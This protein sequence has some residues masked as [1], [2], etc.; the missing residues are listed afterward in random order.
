MNM[1]AL[2]QLKPQDEKTRIQ[3][4]RLEKLVKVP[5]IN[6]I[7][8]VVA[9]GPSEHTAPSVFQAHEQKLHKCTGNI[10]IQQPHHKTYHKKYILRSVNNNSCTNPS[11]QFISLYS[12]QFIHT[13]FFFIIFCY[14]RFHT[15]KRYNIFPHPSQIER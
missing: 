1:S 12:I 10:N 11:I 2:V 8:I 3:Q 6:T 14:N 15:S 5:H 9:Y 4:G 13:Q 7:S